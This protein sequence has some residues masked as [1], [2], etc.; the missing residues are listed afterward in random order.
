VEAVALLAGLSCHTYTDL[1]L[2]HAIATLP[3]GHG[4]VHSALLLFVEYENGKEK[5]KK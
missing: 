5:N 3:T 2:C 4:R 1:P